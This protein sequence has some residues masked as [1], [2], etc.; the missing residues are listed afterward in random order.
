[1]NVGSGPGPR[2]RREGPAPEPS[3]LTRRTV[4]SG[5]ASGRATDVRP[6]SDHHQHHHRSRSSSSWASADRGSE[7][8]HQGR[9][10]SVDRDKSGSSHVSKRNV[11]LSPVVPQPPERR[12][13][14]VI[15][16]PPR[17][18]GRDDSTGVTGPT[19]STEVAD[20]AG[21]MGPAD[22]AADHDSAGDGPAGDHDSAGDEPAVVDDSA[23]VADPAQEEDSA[24]VA[25][26]ADQQ[27]SAVDD[28]ARNAGPVAQGTPAGMT[29][30]RDVTP[31]QQGDT[32]MVSEAS[33]L[34]FPSLPRQINQTSLL[35]L[36]QCG[37]SCNVGW[38]EGCQFQTLSP[39]PLPSNTYT[40]R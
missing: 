28:S 22:S 5:R 10:E 31:D 4:R 14:I 33:S 3:R 7:S 9:R 40:Q 29:P 19:D 8:R 34:L 32:T 35:D 6:S 39:G 1:M 36:C 13:V 16:S 20:S 21:V 26:S 11:E 37:L 30:V 27:D 15:Q 38:T 17:P 18:A 23:G 24:G 12:T 2:L 25:N